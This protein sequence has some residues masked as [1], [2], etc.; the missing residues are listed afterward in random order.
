[1]R[2]ITQCNYLWVLIVI[3]LFNSTVNRFLN[4]NHGCS[5]NK[6]MLGLH[7][8]VYRNQVTLH[9]SLLE[10]FFI[11]LL[12]YLTQSY[13]RQ[14]WYQSYPYQFWKFAHRTL[15][16]K[17]ME[18]GK[19]LFALPICFMFW[20]QGSLHLA[21]ILIARVILRVQMDH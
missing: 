9:F 13:A 16:K 1:M 20:H 14:F 12:L 17:D 7:V 4:S 10:Y 18:I 2:E 3:N 15:L 19:A 6:E 11:A 21:L 8:C 5:H